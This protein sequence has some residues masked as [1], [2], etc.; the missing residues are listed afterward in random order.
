[1]IVTTK[2]LAEK[3]AYF[4]SKY[5]NGQL[6]GIS[7]SI[8]NSR[9]TWGF[10]TYKYIFNDS[11]TEIK[12]IK[13]LSITL[14]NYYDSPEKVKETT[15]L[16]EMIHIADYFFHPEH[17]INLRRTGKNK[18]YDAHG[19]VFFL[20]E[21][22][23]LS[24]DGW[25]IQKYVTMEAKNVSTLSDENEK[26][27]EKKASKGYV[28]C[29]ADSKDRTKSGKWVMKL[30]K[31]RMEYFNELLNTYYKKW[32]QQNFENAKWYESYCI[33]FVDKRKTS[34]K[35]LFHYY[36]KDIVERAMNSGKMKFLGDVFKDEGEG[37]QHTSN[38]PKEDFIH[39]W[40]YIFGRILK[41]KDLAIESLVNSNY[42]FNVEANEPTLKLP[43]ILTT[44]KSKAGIYKDC[45]VFAV[46]ASNLEKALTT[47]KNRY[48]TNLKNEIYV[49]ASTLKLIRKN[50]K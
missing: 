15:L 37:E 43:L 45:V 1:M 48:F 46:N 39:I 20:K 47:Y 7:F 24:S 44:D 35:P 25:E 19:P 18:K 40:N 30:D 6:P 8:S 2:W 23:R 32:M 36:G 33:E 28:V 49:Q 31:S 41:N 26:K 29:I 14:S 50:M 27:L 21:A 17:F 16:H 5:W 4:N 10:A 38:I 13:P 9:K 11:R 34:Q 42:Y 3:Y 12:T 22:E